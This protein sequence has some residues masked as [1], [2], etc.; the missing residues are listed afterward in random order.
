MQVLDAKWE[1]LSNN[2]KDAKAVI[3][4]E[5]IMIYEITLHRDSFRVKTKEL[6]RETIK[7]ELLNPTI[8][9]DIDK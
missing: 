3:N 6:I 1:K 9:I 2:A 8:N 4:N 5:Q 7:A